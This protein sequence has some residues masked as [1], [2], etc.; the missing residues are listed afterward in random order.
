MG[1]SHWLLGGMMLG[2]LLGGIVQLLSG[3]V[4]LL[5]GSV[6]LLGGSV[7]PL[8]GIVYLLLGSQADT[9]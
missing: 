2:G 1:Q 4:Q 9:S 5:G 8:G 6:W 3:I 7:V